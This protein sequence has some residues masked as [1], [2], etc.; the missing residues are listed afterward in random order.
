MSASDTAVTRIADSSE[1][2]NG[3]ATAT[4]PSTTTAISVIRLMDGWP[5]LRTV[6]RIAP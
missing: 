1:P 2:P 4:I 5:D 3:H 6:L